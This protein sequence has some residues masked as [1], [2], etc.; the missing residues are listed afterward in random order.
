MNAPLII[1][2]MN[3]P[4]SIII[5]SSAPSLPHYP[6]PPPRPYFC[7]FI[8]RTAGRGGEGSG[9]R[10]DAASPR[11]GSTGPGTARFSRCLRAG[12]APV[13][14][15]SARW[16][17]ARV[18]RVRVS[19]WVPTP[20]PGRQDGCDLWVCVCAVSAGLPAWG[21]GGECPGL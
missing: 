20:V 4:S 2:E 12:R 21:G 15:R 3:K 19:G 11:C 14:A 1:T 9:P 16:F 10:E 5:S 13:S 18:Q 7:L 17:S 8:H 6:P